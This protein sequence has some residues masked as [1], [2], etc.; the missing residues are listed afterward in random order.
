[1]LDIVI[2]FGGK[3]I[4]TDQKASIDIGCCFWCCLVRR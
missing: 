3:G 4:A 2:R 1:M